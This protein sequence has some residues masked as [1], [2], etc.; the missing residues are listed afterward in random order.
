MA[1][2]ASRTG[3]CPTAR[4]HG[5]TRTGMEAWCSDDRSQRQA[6]AGTNLTVSGPAPSRVDSSNTVH[7][8]LAASLAF[9]G[10]EMR[11]SPSSGVLAR[12]ASAVGVVNAAHVADTSAVMSPTGSVLRDSSPCATSSP[13]DSALSAIISLVADS[14][15]EEEP[16]TAHAGREGEVGDAMNDQ[17]RAWWGHILGRRW[18]MSGLDFTV[19]E[20]TTI[21]QSATQSSLH[22]TRRHVFHLLTDVAAVV[23]VAT[24]VGGLLVDPR[25]APVPPAWPT[26]ALPLLILLVCCRRKCAACRT[27]WSARSCSCCSTR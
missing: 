3:T 11:G 21:L 17:P 12:H 4:A 19:Q 7:S 18:G 22:S 10:D 13:T 26:A 6:G 16:A 1:R 24:R 27:S 25:P 23:K 9:S 20:L 8:A 2:R 14:R 15:A 5:H